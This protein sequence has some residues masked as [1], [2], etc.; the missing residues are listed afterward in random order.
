L[1]RGFLGLSDTKTMTE[2]AIRGMRRAY[3]ADISVIDDAI[4]GIVGALGRK[5]VLDS[6]WVVYTTDHG[7]MAGSHGLMSKCVLYEPAVRVPLI[8]R[9]PGG[10]AP[11]VVDSLVEQLDVPAT[12]REIAG[13]PDVAGSEG[14]SLLGALRGGP[15]PSRDVAVSENWGFAVFETARHKLVIDED[16]M[17]PCQLFDLAEDPAEDED[18]LG[19]PLA[20]GVV[21]EL[22]ETHVRPFFRTP[23]ARPH[24]SILTGGR[25]S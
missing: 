4:G 15:S 13:A 7:E 20:A 1:L 25:T 12:V 3:A 22:M 24:A 8:V 19:D 23:P 17:A 18:R 14:Q 6:T 16:A 11:R 10:C 2:D 21:G 9:P 5:G